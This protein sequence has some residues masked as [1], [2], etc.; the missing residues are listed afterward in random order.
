MRFAASLVTCKNKKLLLTEEHRSLKYGNMAF[1]GT[2]SKPV[3]I[4]NS[5]SM[6]IALQVQV[7]S[8]TVCKLLTG[9]DC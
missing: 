2:K 1:I 6:Q 7:D 8:S 9:R 3:L 4:L 5:L